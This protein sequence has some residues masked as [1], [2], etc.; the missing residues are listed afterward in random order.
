MMCSLL[1]VPRSTYY[2]R[3]RAGRAPSPSA[4]RRAELGVKVM[5]VF[6][7]FGETY[8]A[9][10]IAAVLTERGDPVCPGTVAELMRAQ[11]LVTVQPRAYKVTTVAGEDDPTVPD[12]IGR[13]FTAPAPGQ[14]LVGDIT[15]SAQPLVMCRWGEVSRSA[16]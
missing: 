8:G 2:D 13:D 9:R 14:R 12:L 3:S 15:Y 10:R 11:H 5:E 6:D 4:A 16:W 7:E 1:G